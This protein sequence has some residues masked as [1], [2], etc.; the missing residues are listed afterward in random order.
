[1]E[2]GVRRAAPQTL[3]LVLVLVVPLVVAGATGAAYLLLRAGYGL[4]VGALLPYGISLFLIVA[5]AVAL[6]RTASGRGTGRES[7]GGPRS[8]GRDGV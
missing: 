5:V 4:L 8:R 1:M 2:V 7:G 3:L 6:G